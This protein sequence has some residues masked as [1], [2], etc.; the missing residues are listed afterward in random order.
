MSSEKKNFSLI[1]YLTGESFKRVRDLQ[2]KLSKI[3]GSK[4][5]IEDWLPHITLGDGISVSMNEITKLEALLAMFAR[6]QNIVTVS[7]KNLSG[8]DAWKGAKEGIITPYVIWINVEVNSDL[9]NLFDNLKE[10]VT[11]HYETWLA[12][13]IKY[14]PHITL[15]FADLTEDGYKKGMEYL[16]TQKFE[17]IITISHVALVECYG[18]GGMTSVEHRKFYFS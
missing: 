12:K 3:T 14:D 13:T 2:K 5:C 18:E 16:E 8:T 9:Q 6:N 15:A 11:T 17:D 4:K 1:S 7:V 10:S